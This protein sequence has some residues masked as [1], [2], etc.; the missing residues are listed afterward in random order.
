MKFYFKIILVIYAFT[1][2]FYVDSNVY[3]QY[4]ILK[5]IIKYDDCAINH[6]TFFL[7]N[8]FYTRVQLCLVIKL[9]A[10]I[11]FS[12]RFRIN[13]LQVTYYIHAI[14]YLFRLR[15]LWKR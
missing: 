6:I 13:R 1:A 14:S 5:L 9:I 11:S 7:F 12:Y 3:I 15:C 8:T 10:L 4:K 2:I